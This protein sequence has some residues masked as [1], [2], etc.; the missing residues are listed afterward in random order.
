MSHATAAARR[1]MRGK[2][3]T[4]VLAIAAWLPLN[5]I[6]AE[7]DVAIE[8][9]HAPARESLSTSL[10]RLEVGTAGVFVSGIY[11]EMTR[12]PAVVKFAPGSIEPGWTTM[13]GNSGYATTLDSMKSQRVVALA[14]GESLVMGSDVTRLDAAGDVRW[15]AYPNQ[16]STM[17]AAATLPGGD[18]LI[19]FDNPDSLRRHEGASGKVIRSSPPAMCSVRSMVVVDASSAYVSRVCWN[20]Q[21]P[22]TVQQVAQI[23]PGT[24]DVRWVHMPG[25]V[26]GMAADANG[27][28]IAN[29]NTIRKLAATDGTFLWDA[30][31]P[32]GLRLLGTADNGDI[33]ASHDGG[34]LGKR[35]ERIDKT[36]GIS[37]WTRDVAGTSSARVS[38]DAVVMTG[39]TVIGGVD[40]PRVQVVDIGSGALAWQADIDVPSGT[41]VRVSDAVANGSHVAVLGKQCP[42]LSG[43]VRCEVRMWH[44]QRASGVVAATQPLMVRSAVASDTKMTADGT[45]RTAAIDW[46]TSG[47]RLRLFA[48]SASDGAVLAETTVGAPMSTTAAA[49]PADNV[50]LAIGTN[51]HLAVL[52][53]R[54]NNSL[55]SAHD[56]VVLSFDAVGAFRWR[57]S[58]LAELAGQTG[59]TAQLASVDSAGNVLLGKQ[60]LFGQPNAW[61]GYTTTKRWM[62]RLAGTTG[63]VEW[64]REFRAAMPGLF[65]PNP[66][67]GLPVNNDILVQEAPLGETWTGIARL[68]GGDGATQW[69]N[70]DAP[71][72]S[73]V[74]RP[75]PL[76]VLTVATSAQAS[77]VRINHATGATDWMAQYPF[78]GDQFYFAWKVLETAIDNRYLLSTTRRTI[79]QAGERNAAFVLSVDVQTGNAEWVNRFDADMASRFERMDPFG[80]ANG[81]IHATGPS[82]SVANYVV[83][84]TTLDAASGVAQDARALWAST[85]RVVGNVPQ[86]IGDPIKLVGTDAL[87]QWPLRSRLGESPYLTLSRR[88]LAQ[89]AS[90]VDIGVSLDWS[91]TMIGGAP[92]TQVTYTAANAGP[93]SAEAVRSVID[94]P[95]DSPLLD[96]TCTIDATPCSVV[97]GAAWIEGVHTLPAGAQ[98]LISARFADTAT[99]GTT[100]FYSASAIGS[101][102]LVEPTLNDNFAESDLGS[103]DLIFRTGFDR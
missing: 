33:I 36:S 9:A 46:T 20:P 92:A 43:E 18:V 34:S 59:V 93:D 65:I 53:K 26:Q 41:R 91:P 78:P 44:L 95:P 13:L 49:L 98:L 16:Q 61:T 76:S 89:Q 47:Q 19:A 73:G 67:I 70:A 27:V 38:G 40:V 85:W 63:D 86:G 37:L 88:E 90:S 17:Q 68:S 6:A 30:Y 21:E 100:G 28:Y 15:A 7:W 10:A 3:G 79:D 51:G 35:V 75:G 2:L 82:R 97:V 54:R 58:L 52:V 64:Q 14:D 84:M 29:G 4:M 50:S 87:L 25:E 66:P 83:G 101:F 11:E 57:K 94:M 77:T 103:G 8:G 5:G 22:T 39:S 31:R 1:G 24:L 23:D 81:R 55:G 56:A 48:H 60:E 42:G 32:A 69:T 45:I 12:T 96:V 72:W 62:A 80:I 102:R 74:Y 71:Q 99:Y